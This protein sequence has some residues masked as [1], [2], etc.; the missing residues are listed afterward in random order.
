[1]FSI[2][3][4]VKFREG[5]SFQSVG[6]VAFRI[7]NKANPVRKNKY[8]IDGVRS[9]I[10]DV[11]GLLRSKL[12]CIGTEDSY[13]V[14]IPLSRWGCS[15]VA[16]VGY[17]YRRVIIN[18][19][20][21]SYVKSV[22]DLRKLPLHVLR[23]MLLYKNVF[24]EGAGVAY[25]LDYINQIGLRDIVSDLNSKRHVFVDDSYLEYIFGMVIN[26]RCA[27]CGNSLCSLQTGIVDYAYFNLSWLGSL[28]SMGYHVF[29][30]AYRCGECRAF[31]TL[32]SRME[33]KELHF[34]PSCADPI[35]IFTEDFSVTYYEKNG[36]IRI[37]CRQ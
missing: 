4:I 9:P 32:I 2:G 26:H 29:P 11:S 17:R 16:H 25:T 34:T 15:I 20:K 7:R 24:E 5:I 22:L 35:R 6:K 28:T 31:N 36:K 27:Q 12:L 13:N 30:V 1:M 10:V 18:P 23:D 8:S 37:V 3:D 33:S 21:L 14:F 19:A